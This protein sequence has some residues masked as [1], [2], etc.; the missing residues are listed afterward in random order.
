VAAAEVQRYAASVAPAKK[1]EV[2]GG[3]RKFFRGKKQLN[4]DRTLADG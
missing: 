1:D 2:T 4:K 3:E